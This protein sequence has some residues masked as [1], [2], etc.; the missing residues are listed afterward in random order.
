MRQS[1][2]WFAALLL[3][4][5]FLTGCFVPL[6][7]AYP[8]LAHVSAIDLGPSAQEI[9]AFRVTVVDQ[10]V[11]IDFPE[12][13]SYELS[14]IPLSPAG[15]MP[16]QTKLAVDYGWVWNCVALVYGGRT[17]HT[18][19]VRLY[20]PGWQTI[21]INSWESTRQVVWKPA[22]DL[23]SQEK[24]VDD[25]VSTWETDR[26]AIFGRDAGNDPKSNLA[27]RSLAPGSSSAE[28]REALRFLAAEYERLAKLA[29]GDQAREEIRNRLS[30]K[31]DHLRALSHE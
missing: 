27:C 6:G 21:E 31:A 15:N 24:A 1:P 30:N 16:S 10:Q 7:Y 2:A 4:C 26:E 9:H 3:F 11:C 23:A 8:S 17:H 22:I 20:R 12:K 13:D 14:R 18:L 25:V 29:L 5:P 19:L 28:H